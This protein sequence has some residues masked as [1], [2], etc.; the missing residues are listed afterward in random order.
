VAAT[1]R[2]RIDA[3]GYRADEIWI[4]EVKPDAGASAVGQ[5][6]TYKTLYLDEYPAP[7]K[8]YLA[9][10]TNQLRH[11]MERVFTEHGIRWFVVSV[12]GW[13]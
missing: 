3:I 11:D 9:V 10:I 12:P 5:L 2:Y 4:L 7:N 1:S 8:L 13:I 6:L